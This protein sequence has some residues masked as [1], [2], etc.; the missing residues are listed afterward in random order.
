MTS[1]NMKKCSLSFANRELQIKTAMRYHY[2]PI[3]MTKIQNTDN[4][5]CF[6][7]CGATGFSFTAH[8]NT[9]GVETLKIV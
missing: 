6:Q 5:E 1:P 2:T 8:E 4:A 3:T 7:G 9:N